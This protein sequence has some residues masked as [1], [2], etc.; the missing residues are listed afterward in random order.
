LGQADDLTPLYRQ[1]G[2]VYGAP[3]EEEAAYY[4]AIQ[5][6]DDPRFAHLLR[7]FMISRQSRTFQMLWDTLFTMNE[8]GLAEWVYLQICQQ[9]LAALSVGAPGEQ[10]VIVSGH[11]VTPLGGYVL[12]NRCHF[13]LAS[14]THARP[15]EAGRYLLLNC[16]SPVHAANDL[17][18][19]LGSVFE[20]KI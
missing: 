10:R 18:G 1:Y 3:Y 14:A 11:I 13:R 4:L 7:A 17:I 20:E 8:T 5:G 12:V 6:P 16:A 2:A 9:F 15:R 19:C